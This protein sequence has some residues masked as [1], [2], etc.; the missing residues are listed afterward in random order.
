MSMNWAVARELCFRAGSERLTSSVEVPLCD[1]AAGTLAR[2]VHA[3]ADLPGFASSAMD[4]WVV[5]GSGPWQLAEPI[6]TGEA[7]SSAPLAPGWARPICTGAPV[8]PGSVAVLRTENGVALDDR[9]LAHPSTTTLVEGADI[10]PQGEEARTR[11]L[12]LAS[13]TRLTPAALALAAVSG[14]DTVTI[15]RE[16]TVSLVLLGAEILTAGIPPAGHVRDAYGI[17]LPHLLGQQGAKVLDVLHVLDDSDATVAGFSRVGPQLIIS[18][19]GSSHGMTDHVRSALATLNAELLIDGVAMR[20]GHPVMLAVRPDGTLILC[21][22]GNPLAAMTALLTLGLALIDGMLGR[23]LAVDQY[24]VAGQDMENRSELSVRVVAYRL[25]GGRAVLT[26]FQGSGM[27]RGLVAADGLAVVP[28]RGAR[29]GEAV[30]RIP[31]PW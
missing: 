4:G 17:P 3:L 12:L 9:V 2:S 14:I 24:V 29:A 20:P 7:P 15:R 22:P 21:L 10:R 23:H 30:L 27:L 16:P 8:P 28:A 1:A 6:L 26:P 31:L 25:E 11:E 13:G 18:T 5:S 19:G